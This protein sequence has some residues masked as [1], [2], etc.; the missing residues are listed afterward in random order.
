MPRDIRILD[1]VPQPDD[2][3]GTTVITGSHGGISSGRYAA[4][5]GV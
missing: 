2:A 4:S 5:L 3:T 1:I